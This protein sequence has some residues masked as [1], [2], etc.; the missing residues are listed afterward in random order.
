MHL[1]GGSDLDLGPGEALLLAGGVWHEHAPLRPG[2]VWYGQG[3]LAAWSDV[4]MGSAARGWSGRMPAEPSRRIM[5]AALATTDEAQAMRLVAGLVGQ[6]LSESVTHLGFANPAMRAMVDLLWR[7]CHLGVT[8]AELVAA[9]GLQR[10]Q[11]YR[12]FTEGF[13]LTPKDAI[14]TTRLWLA[15]SYLKAGMGVAEVAA[16]AGY[17]SA[18]TFARC[19]RRA[20]GKS[21]SVTA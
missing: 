21:P 11:A 14:A 20:H 2:S 13:G 3:F 4:A 19:W 8:V 16:L 5:E 18:D 1:A 10:A 9:S 7:R 6:V 15:G 12:V 17:P